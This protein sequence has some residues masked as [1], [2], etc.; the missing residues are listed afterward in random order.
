MIYKRLLFCIIFLFLGGFG[1]GFSQTGNSPLEENLTQERQIVHPLQFDKEQIEQYKNDQ[2]FNYVEKIP[3]E[4]WWTLFKDWIA[5]IWNQFW[6]WLL[7]S[8]A[9]KGIIALFLKI[10]PYLII[11]A[12]IGFVVWLFIKL[13]PAAAALNEKKSSM[14][15]L[16]EEEKILKMEDIPALI[17]K[18]VEQKNF[19][20]AVRYYYLLVLKKLGDQKQIDYQ[21]QKTNAEYL[22]EIQSLPVKSQ[23][24]Y[25]TH[26]YDFIWYGDF[27]LTEPDFKKAENEFKHMTTLLNPVAFGKPN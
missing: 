10:I 15:H 7:G 22:S 1:P 24:E 25:I 13:N 17:Q 11:V 8:Y 12:I 20:S 6:T 9:A 2:D 21:F 16:S 26:L 27:P 18:A 4:N 23:F 3:T 5:Y 19:R 14:V